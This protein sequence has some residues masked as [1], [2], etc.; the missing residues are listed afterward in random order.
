VTV[1]ELQ[2]AL[3]ALKQPHAEVRLVGWVMCMEQ[4]TSSYADVNIML[5]VVDV[6]ST[7]PR[8]VEVVG[9]EA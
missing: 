8:V 3:T 7:H 6:R 2:E 1:Q 9:E 4:H 5:D